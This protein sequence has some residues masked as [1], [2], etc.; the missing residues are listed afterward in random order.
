MTRTP[1]P[2]AQQL[3]A[4][5]RQVLA[6]ADTTARTEV[7]EVLIRHCDDRIAEAPPTTFADPGELVA[8]VWREALSRPPMP[9]V[10]TEAGAIGGQ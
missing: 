6:W 7:L 3:A 1:A 8:R 4:S 2:S 10:I 5:I 9:V